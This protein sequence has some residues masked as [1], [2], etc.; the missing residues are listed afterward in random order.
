RVFE[1]WIREQF[2]LYKMPVLRYSLKYLTEVFNDQKNSKYKLDAIELKA[3]LEK[4]GLTADVQQRLKIP[5]GFNLPEEGNRSVD[6]T[7]LYNHQLGRPYKFVAQEWLSESQ[8]EEF[9]RPFNDLGDGSNP[10]DKTLN[11]DELPF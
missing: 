8:M 5:V 3:Y 11:G 4:K 1:D 7:I 2:L 10:A 6:V 9:S